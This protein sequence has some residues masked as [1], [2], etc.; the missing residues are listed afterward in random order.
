MKNYKLGTTGDRILTVKKRGPDYFVMIR[1]K[2]DDK[3]SI[4]LS[5]HRWASFRQY[6]DDITSNVKAVTAGEEDIKLCQHIG[7]GHYVSVTSGYRCVDFRRWFQ[8]YG[9]KDGE[10]K[11]TKNGVALRFEEWFD[12]CTLVDAINTAYP[13][14][15]TALPCYYKED[16]INPPFWL[17]CAECHPFHD[18]LSQM[19]SVKST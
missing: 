14:L 17:S 16:H 15:G 5:P 2:D 19:S 1:M 11:P 10:I 3:K 13:S 9:P 8:P 18:H 7:G 12:L 6:I 4:E